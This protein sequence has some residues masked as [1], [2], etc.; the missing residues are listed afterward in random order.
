MSSALLWIA[1]Y[2]CE[3][4]EPIDPDGGGDD[5]GGD[6]AGG[7]DGAGD[8]GAGDDGGGDGGGDDG[9]S[10]GYVPTA[11]TITLPSA[12]TARQ[13]RSTRSTSTARR[14][15]PGSRSRRTTTPVRSAPCCS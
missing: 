9:G 11:F 6:D 2:G 15:I 4:D 14:T 1:L 13:A 5:G 7:D 3:P 12:S 10:D 8:D